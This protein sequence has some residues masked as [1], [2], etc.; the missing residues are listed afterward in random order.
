[1]KAAG[2]HGHHGPVTHAEQRRRNA[3]AAAVL[4]LDGGKEESESSEGDVN[5]ARKRETGSRIGGR[6]N[7]NHAF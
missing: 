1:M 2:I 7:E 6:R 4:V 5:M 3:T